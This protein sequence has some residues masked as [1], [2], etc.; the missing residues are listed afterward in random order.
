MWFPLFLLW[1]LLLLVGLVVL[2]LLPIAV[3][4]TLPLRRAPQ[5]L[6]AARFVPHLL[7][8]FVSVRG[9]HIEVAGSD[10]EFSMK[11]V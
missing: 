1:P 3:I 4:V 10:N 7:R 2:A 11:L 9:L 8:L 5:V 6:R